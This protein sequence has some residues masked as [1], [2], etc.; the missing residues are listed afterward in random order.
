MGVEK[1]TPPLQPYF[2]HSNQTINVYSIIFCKEDIPSESTPP[3]PLQKIARK[4]PAYTLLVT[5]FLLWS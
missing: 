4:I 5:F 3:P 1:G 2:P